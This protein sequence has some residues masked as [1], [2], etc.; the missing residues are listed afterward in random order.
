MVEANAAPDI[1]SRGNPKLP[2][3]KTKTKMIRQDNG[4]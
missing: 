1:P 4:M 3:I 2:N